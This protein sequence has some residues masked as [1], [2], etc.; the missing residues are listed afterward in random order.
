VLTIFAA[1]KPFTGDVARI[2]ANALRSWTALPDTDVIVFGDEPGIGA[3]AHATGARH[4]A[5][6]GRSPEG[7]PLFDGMLAQAKAL[8]R[9][10]VLCFVNA[11]VLLFPDLTAAVPIARHAFERF[12]LFG[13]RTNLD[14]A[15]EIDVSE[16]GW[17]GRLREQA[18]SKGVESSP[19]WIDYFVFPRGLFGEIP[20]LVVG[21]A[22]ID[23]WLLWKARS[24]GAALVDASRNVLVVHQNHDYAHHADGER[25]VWKGAEAQRN[26][27]L[28]GGPERRYYVTDATHRLVDGR[29]VANWSPSRLARGAS[30]SPRLRPA[31]RAIR[32]VLA[33]TYPLRRRLGLRRHSFSGTSSKRP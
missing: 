3:A 25:G 4:V 8:A 18:Q 17:A 31:Q 23:N 22:G 15:G 13:R 10:D 21:R 12:L 24:E 7:T 6:V 19:E 1:P 16:S 30:R 11:D 28:I 9:H 14:V 2:Q 27:R 20:P 32:Y 26:L 29:V 5:E 33:A